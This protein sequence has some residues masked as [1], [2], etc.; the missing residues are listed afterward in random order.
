MIFT[1][2]ILIGCPSSGKST[3]A[4]E[5][6][7]NDQNCWIISTDQIRQKLYGNAA[8]QGNWL[9]IEKEIFRQIEQYL[10]AGHSI[11][12]DATN[13]KPSWRRDF[14]EK[15]T[16]F[17]NINWIGWYLKTPLE[18]CLKWNRQRS[19][20]V[21]SDIIK[22]FYE[23]LQEFPP[24][25]TEGLTTIYEIPY[26]NNNLDLSVISQKNQYFTP[27]NHHQI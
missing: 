15:A 6:Q 3:V 1:G 12:Y 18:V 10:G 24:T 20:Q 7:Q 14:L 4:H 21:P 8:I 13:A 2:H 9:E 22:K 19:R 25:P 11:I 26:H 27:E 23:N 17:D 16:Q 5:I